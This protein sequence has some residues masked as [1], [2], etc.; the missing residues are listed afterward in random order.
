MVDNTPK[1]D[2][3]KKKFYRKVL[4]G[5]NIYALNVFKEGLN[6]IIFQPKIIYFL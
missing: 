5:H 2:K 3:L 1:F 4:V 6:L